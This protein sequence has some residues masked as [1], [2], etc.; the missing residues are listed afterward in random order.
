MSTSAQEPCGF[1]DYLDYHLMETPDFQFLLRQDEEMM[2]EMMDGNPQAIM[3]HNV[4][5]IPVVFHIIHLGENSSSNISDARIIQALHDL[6]SDFR[7]YQMTGTDVEI[8]FCLAQQDPN[9]VSHYN[10]NGQNVTGIQRVNGFGTAGYELFGII[11]GQNGN[12][13]TIKNL[14]RWPNTDYINIWVVHDIE[15]GYGGYATFP[16][17]PA[18]V[19]GIVLLDDVTGNGFNSKV[20][21][22]EMGHF[23][24]LY[25][26][27]HNS[28][29]PI[30]CP[31]NANCEY[32]GD[33]ICDT[34][35]HVYLDSP[36]WFPC[37]EAQYLYCDNSNFANNVIE[38]HMNYTDNNCRDEFT[39]QQVLRMRTTLMVARSSL[40]NSVACLPACPEVQVAF[41][42]TPST[43][44]EAGS[45]VSFMN[46]STGAN[47]Y[48]W[49]IGMQTFSSTNLN[50]TFTTKG[51]YQVCLTGYGDDCQNRQ[52]QTVKVID[53]LPCFSNAT[54]CNPIRNGDFNESNYDYADEAP[55]HSNAFGNQ[56]DLVCNWGNKFRSP[57]LY[58]HNGIVAA[59]IVGGLRRWQEGIVTQEPVNFEA[60][61]WYLI[62]VD[63]LFS[64]CADI[65]ASSLIVGFSDSNG[66]N[67]QAGDEEL[68]RITDTELFNECFDTIARG[69]S[70]I[71]PEDFKQHYFYYYSSVAHSKHIYL[72]SL[73]DLD[74][75]DHTVHLVERIEICCSEP[76][77]VD[78]DMIF[79]QNCPKIFTVESPEENV[80][81]SWQFRCIGVE[82]TGESVTLD[83]PPGECE[84]CLIANCLIEGS[85]I[86]CRTINVPEESEECRSSCEDLNIVLQ[87]CEQDT[88]QENHFVAQVVLSVPDG[89]VPCEGVDVLSNSTFVDI[90]LT[91][92]SIEDDPNNPSLDNI[93]LGID[94]NA[95]AGIDVLNSQ[96][97]G[98]IN[99]CTADGEILCYNLT[100][101]GSECANCLGEITATAACADP[102]P[103]DDEYVYE[104][105]V[106]IELPTG[107]YEECDPVSTEVGY[108]QNVSFGNS[109]ATV[110]FTINTSTSG[111]FDASTLICILINGI[112]YCYTLNIEIEPCQIPPTDCIQEWAPKPTTD[113]EVSDDGMFTFSFNMY[114]V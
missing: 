86:I 109:K 35:S 53:S 30:D 61:Q 39:P 11:A 32:D 10:G 97:A 87:T 67:E 70:H 96:M 106:T 3:N 38:N 63:Y 14:S 56:F 33:R 114:N 82:M 111:D 75:P 45:S 17:S 60:D 19:D 78:L 52:C 36:I 107:T 20:I 41:T 34:R 80:T 43:N 18:A 21:T 24:W 59:S 4:Y 105:S 25:H 44:V 104:G 5:T 37:D 57:D 62:K 2:H 48:L 54:V 16:N 93:T 100:F 112:Q 50:Y 55:Y 15:G 98:A 108:E 9:G 46:Q 58:L 28:Q 79:D 90:N 73:P 81:Y 49:E 6:N 71:Q 23:F 66:L 13:A 27:F 85:N 83:L 72:S 42:A 88:S 102:N 8:E 7:D 89:T 12:E 31:S 94:V 40:M 47:S 64:S 84:V 77:C 29:S 91:S 1:D 103:F 51:F 110:D 99:L 22:H 26:T 95:P 101:T 113:C 74:L 65:D 69:V 76:P 68:F 92:I